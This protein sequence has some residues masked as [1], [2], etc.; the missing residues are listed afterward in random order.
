MHEIYGEKFLPFLNDS[1]ELKYLMRNM[2]ENTNELQ[3]M[4]HCLRMKKK[5]LLNILAAQNLH[6]CQKTLKIIKHEKVF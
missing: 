1:Q 4:L 2:Y 6:I 5:C 3:I